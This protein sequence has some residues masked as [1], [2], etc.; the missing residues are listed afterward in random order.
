M[1]RDNNHHPPGGVAPG[2]SERD[3]IAEFDGIKVIIPKGYSK[4]EYGFY[5][6]GHGVEYT[7]VSYGNG[8]DAEICLETV[9]SKHVR[10]IPLKR[11][12]AIG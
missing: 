7:L 10:I 12:E 5:M 6:D 1:L 3:M 2:E 4:N 8:D 9:Y 11:V